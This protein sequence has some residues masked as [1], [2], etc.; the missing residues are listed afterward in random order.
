MK[1]ARNRNKRTEKKQM[2]LAIPVIDGKISAHFGHCETFELIDVDEK[3]KQVLTHTSLP[4]P[5][6]Q[7][8]LL[9]RW[10]GEQ[11]IQI[12]IA[13]GIG[14]RARDL[15]QQQGIDV[16]AGVPEGDPKVLVDQYLNGTLVTGE[17]TCDHD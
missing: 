3:S 7:P 4:S 15:F 1:S 10:L 12:L 6:H 8:G 13:G 11:G 9:P 5:D 17:N 16:I 2:R 14:T